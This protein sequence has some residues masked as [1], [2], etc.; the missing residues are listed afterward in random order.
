MSDESLTPRQISSRAA[1][2]KA[3]RQYEIA[4]PGDHN[5]RRREMEMAAREVLRADVEAASMT[6]GNGLMALR[7]GVC[8]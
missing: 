2:L 5:R 7:E 1:H 6:S 4:E 8:K 3:R